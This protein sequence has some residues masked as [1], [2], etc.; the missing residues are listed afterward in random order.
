MGARCIRPGLCAVLTGRR[1]PPPYP[2][3]ALSEL[4]S[5]SYISTAVRVLSLSELDH[6]LQRSQRRNTRENVTGLL[7]PATVRSPSAS[8]GRWTEW[9]ASLR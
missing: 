2:S 7:L 4:V 1:T 6:L 3:N 9:N 5:L 8:K